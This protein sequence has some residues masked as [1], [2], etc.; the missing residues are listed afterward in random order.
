MGDRPFRQ[1][2]AEKVRWYLGLDIDPEKQI[3]VIYEST[4]AMA[5]VMLAGAYYL[6][7][8]ISSVGYDTDIEFTNY[9]IKEIGVAVVPGSS[10]FCRPEDGQRFIR[11]C[12]SKTTETFERARK[13]LLK[14]Q[15]TLRTRDLIH[16]RS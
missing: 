14:L 12:F 16:S 6:F 5:A 4:E 11:F 8:D 13:R 2:I 3:I 1:A 9:L 10:F 15:P 7:A